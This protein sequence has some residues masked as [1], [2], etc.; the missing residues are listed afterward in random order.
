MTPETFSQ[1]IEQVAPG[2]QIKLVLDTVQFRLGGKAFATLNWPA[3]GWAVVKLS[4]ADQRLALSRSEAFA[5]EPGRRRP[6]VTL[7]R[8]KG[9]DQALMAEVLAAAWREAY[10]VTTPRRGSASMGA[11][12]ER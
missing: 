3:K 11:G 4:S 9:V 6:G 10:Q 7:V 12:L 8:L 5:R 2:A 1:L